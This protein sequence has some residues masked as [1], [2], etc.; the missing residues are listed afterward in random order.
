MTVSKLIRVVV[1]GYGVLGLISLLHADELSKK[2]LAVVYEETK[3]SQA[4]F[5]TAFGYFSKLTQS[6]ELKSAE[7]GSAKI[8]GEVI[9]IQ[10]NTDDSSTAKSERDMAVISVKNAI[11]ASNTPYSSRFTAL[12]TNLIFGDKSLGYIINP[13]RGCY[14]HD[15]FVKGFEKNGYQLVDV[16]QNPDITISIGIDACMTEN[17]YKEYIQKNTALRLKTQTAST[18]GSTSSFG[19][20]LMRAGSSAQLGTPSGGGNAGLAVA[21]VGLALNLANWLTTKTPQEKDVIRY[22]VTFSGKDKQLFEFYPMI[23][24]KETHKEGNPLYI[25]S[26]HEAE[27]ALFS[28]FLAWEIDPK[29]LVRKL[30]S[31]VL[32]KDMIKMTEQIFS[33]K[34]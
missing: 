12:A 7:L 15:Y 27:Q 32:E 10:T 33:Q 17:E 23:I 11:E 25:G 2:T 20:D 3:T 29:E 9:D 13:Y 16:N 14:D 19:N 21:G 4:L 28:T 22:H 24:T 5:H 6:G 34:K 8:F 31:F 26:Y 1:A 30:P 18:D